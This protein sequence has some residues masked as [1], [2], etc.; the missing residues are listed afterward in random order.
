MHKDGRCKGKD[1]RDA[2]GHNDCQVAS[3]LPA[4]AALTVVLV[5]VVASAGLAKDAKGPICWH[6]ARYSEFTR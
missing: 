6:V 3:A 5:I 1:D 2:Q 4:L